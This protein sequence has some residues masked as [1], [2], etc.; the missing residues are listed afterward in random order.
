MFKYLCNIQ[1]NTHVGYPFLFLN[2]AYCGVLIFISLFD[3]NHL[4]LNE[5]LT[6]QSEEDIFL[7]IYFEKSNRFCQNGK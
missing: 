3:V 2:I 5:S 4:K 7:V 1:E 6:E